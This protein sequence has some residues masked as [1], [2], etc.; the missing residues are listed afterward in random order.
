MAARRKNMTVVTALESDEAYQAA[1]EKS[2]QYLTIIDIHQNWCGPCSIM[3]PIYRKAYLELERAEERLKFYTIDEAKLSAESRAGL[4]ITD[5]CKPLFV[6]FKVRTRRAPRPRPP[7]PRSRAHTPQHTR[8]TRRPSAR[9]WVRRGPS[10]SPRCSIMFL[11][12]LKTKR[13]K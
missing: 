3:E 12:S 2:S 5:S 7:P 8:R 10:W 4:P 1:V 9:S 13:A 6:V 11:M